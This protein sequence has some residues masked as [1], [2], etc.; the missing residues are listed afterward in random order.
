MSGKPLKEPI[1]WGGPLVMNTEEELKQAV[2][3]IGDGT[4]I[5]KT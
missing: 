2:K 3:E 5:K 1:A 4:F